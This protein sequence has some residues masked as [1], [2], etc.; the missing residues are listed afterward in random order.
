[1]K[2]LLSIL[3]AIGLTATN[4][5]SLVACDKPKPNN[6]SENR[7]NKPE[8]QKPSSG[9]YESIN[10]KTN[11]SNVL[12]STYLGEL[13]NNQTET[14]LNKILKLNSN[15]EKNSIEIG[16]V[17]DNWASIIPT[18][19]SKYEGAVMINFILNKNNYS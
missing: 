2:K 15:V 19:N 5:T 11:L 18:S 13:Q 16:T 17:I 10:K 8:P 7:N 1:M 4:T 3:G 6:N 14:I 12:I 9:G